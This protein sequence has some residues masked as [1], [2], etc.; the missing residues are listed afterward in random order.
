MVAEPQM[1]ARFVPNRSL[2]PGELPRLLTRNEVPAFSPSPETYFHAKS[3]QPGEL[4]RLLTRNEV[5]A[6]SPS[7][8]TY[9]QA[10]SLQPGELPRL[11]TRNEVPAFSPSPETYFHATPTAFPDHGFARP[12]TIPAGPSGGGTDT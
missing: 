5:P 11:P 12:G 2:Q 6:L 4:P 10:R 3:L 9:F 1:V 8:E 7:P